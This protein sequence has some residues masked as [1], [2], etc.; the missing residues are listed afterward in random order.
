MSDEKITGVVLAGGLGRRMGGIDKGLQELRGRPMVHWVIER[1]APQVDE[2]LINANQNGERYAAFG[3]RVVPDEIPDFAGPLAGLHAALS[4]AAHPLVA[5]A[6][7]DSPFLPADLISRLFQAL[8]ATGADLAV[9]RTFDQPHPVFCLCRR[10]VLPH[11]T[12]F[13]AGGGRKIDRWYATLRVVEVAFDDEADAFEN[14]NTREE[15]GRFET[16]GEN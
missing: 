5:T 3:H 2:L 1:L 6:P 8:T 9:A 16:T 14:I 10:A 11:L 12:E 13:L 7:C 4:A 15:L